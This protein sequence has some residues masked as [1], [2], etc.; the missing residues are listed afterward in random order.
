MKKFVAVL[1]FLTLLIVGMSAYTLRIEAYDVNSNATLNAQIY[2]SGMFTGFTTPHDFVDAAF[3]PGDYS[4]QL[5][6]YDYWLPAV[7]TFNAIT[8]TVTFQFFATNICPVN[9]VELS[10][11]T[12]VTMQNNVSL[13]WVS[14]SELNM[15]GYRVY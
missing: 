7:V 2:R 3:L 12:A 4:C 9:P 11:F 6:C 14:Q 5:Q 13:Q 15:L 8:A 10:S 1:I